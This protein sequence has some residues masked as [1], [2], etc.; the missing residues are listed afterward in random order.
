V[1]R[2]AGERTA[3]FFF[4]FLASDR[5]SSIQ[6]LGPAMETSNAQEHGAIDA[7]TRADSLRPLAQADESSFFFVVL[8]I[9]SDLPAA[10]LD[11]HFWKQSDLYQFGVNRAACR[12]HG[13]R[14]DLV[15]IDNSRSPPTAE[16]ISADKS[17]QK[18]P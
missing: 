1:V 14:S 10:L 15:K 17:Q 4:F 13:N 18:P 7:R 9:G 3:G 5:I 16:Q 8:Q 12:L 11:R 6:L 2:R